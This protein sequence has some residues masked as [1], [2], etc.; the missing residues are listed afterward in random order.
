MG[1]RYIIVLVLGLKLGLQLVLENDWGA[2]MSPEH[3]SSLYV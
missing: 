3:V 1:V 2:M